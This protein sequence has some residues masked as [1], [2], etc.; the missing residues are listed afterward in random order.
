MLANDDD[1]D[2]TCIV[3]CIYHYL[4]TTRE[5]RVGV[6]SVASVFLC[7]FFCLVRA[8]TFESLDLKASLYASTSLEYLGKVPNFN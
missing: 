5:R 8:L 3:E 1:D 2:V 6:R 4:I 7:V